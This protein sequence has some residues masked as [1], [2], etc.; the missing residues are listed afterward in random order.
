M[1]AIR[2]GFR[3]RN[4][5]PRLL[6]LCAGLNL[7]ILPH[8]SRMPLWIY[9]LVVALSLWRLAL[10]EAKLQ[11]PAATLVPQLTKLLI[12]LTIITGILMSYGTLVGRDAGVALLI[13][14]AGLKFLE[15]FQERDYYVSAYIGL[16]IVLTRFLYSQSIPM[17]IYMFFI[18]VFLS[19]VLISI[20]DQGNSLNTRARLTA[21]GVIVLQSIP[22]MLVI[23]L[24]FPRVPG[25]LWGL[26]RDADRGLAGL[27]DE[28]APGT[29]SQL[30]LSDKIAFRVKFAGA[31]P[32]Q[33]LLYWRGPVLWQTDGVKW[34]QDRPRRSATQVTHRGGAIEYTVTLEA[35]NQNWLFGLE[36]PDKP[37]ADAIF[38][39][40]MQTRSRAPV[41]NITRYTLVSYTDYRYM[42]SDPAEL[43]RATQL[44][45]GYHPRAKALGKSWRDAGLADR[46]I[47]G[48]ALQMFNAQDF[49]YTL[50]PPQ[51]LQDTVDQFLFDARRGFCEHYAAAFVVLMRAAG[52]PARVI[53]GYQGGTLNTIDDYLVVRQRDAHAWAE[54]WL[55]DRGWTRVDPTSAVS[56]TRISAGIENALPD[57]IIDIPLGFQQNPVVLNLWRQLRDTYEALNN[58]WNQWVLS[59][60]SK[61]QRNLLIHLG[62]KKVDWKGLA[63]WLVCATGIMFALV[64][65]WLFRQS[66]HRGDPVQ[67]LYDK[68]CG[69][70]AVV[71][72]RR[73][74]SEG[75][76]DFAARAGDMREDLSPAISEITDLYIAVRYGGEMQALDPLRERT[77]TFRPSRFKPG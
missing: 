3:L 25:P 60:D 72:I 7:A 66:G 17:A 40:D 34:I 18:V 55:A 39:H 77:R 36:M 61:R 19:A 32:D 30:T 57:S 37:P 10:P 9:L 49:Y 22:L 13:S 44:P 33:S 51:Y 73:G 59:Y 50:N 21:A 53:T 46:Q 64:S 23:F 42:L 15:T 29:I 24:L 43:S 68:F 26:P 62:M 74:L 67:G 76:Q 70:L 1:E 69:R 6:W 31:V 20:N 71:G 27:S 2:T 54:V 35:T 41:R 5:S 14:L 4:V 75:P 56:P 8:C 45:Q 12:G 47:V 58:G 16:F 63:V 28:M 52:I 65:L 38:T 11:R 48:R